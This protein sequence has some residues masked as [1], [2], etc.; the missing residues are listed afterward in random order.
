MVNNLNRNRTI[1]PAKHLILFVISSH[2]FSPNKFQNTTMTAEWNP[3]I[4]LLIP[5]N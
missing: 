3:V 4:I 5:N 2:I 1:T